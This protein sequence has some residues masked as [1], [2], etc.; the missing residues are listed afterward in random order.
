MAA[1]ALGLLSDSVIEVISLAN[2][3]MTFTQPKAN[4]GA[5]VAGMIFPMMI[6][7]YFLFDSN[8]RAAFYT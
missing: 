8:V 6:L 7:F 3:V 4:D 2:S 1:C 5:I